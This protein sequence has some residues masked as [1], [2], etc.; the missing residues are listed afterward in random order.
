MEYYSTIKRIL[1]LAT[2]WMY[3]EN[4][5]LSEMSEKDKRCIISFICG[6]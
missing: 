3:L 2:M 5:M 4:I 1:P 6:I